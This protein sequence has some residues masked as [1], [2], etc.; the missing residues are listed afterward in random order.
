V[1]K[2]LETWRRPHTTLLDITIRSS[3]VSELNV[4]RTELHVE[5]G[6]QYSSRGITGIS[7]IGH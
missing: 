1:P 3:L 2:D 5:K 4:I 7:F 6:T